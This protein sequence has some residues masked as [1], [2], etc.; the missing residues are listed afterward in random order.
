MSVNKVLLKHGH[1]HLFGSFQGMVTEFSSDGDP[2]IVS[3]ATPKLFALW[4]FTETLLTYG[5]DAVD[6]IRIERSQATF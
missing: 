2:G 4:S 6:R 1:N 5:L 3:P